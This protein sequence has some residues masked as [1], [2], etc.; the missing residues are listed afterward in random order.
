[1]NIYTQKLIVLSFLLTVFVFHTSKADFVISA[2]GRRH[3]EHSAF[4]ELPFVDGDMS[5]S[6][7]ME[8][9]ESAG[10]WQ[11][12]VGYAP[13][14]GNATNNIDYVLTPQLNVLFRDG[15][16]VGGTGIL[17]SRVSTNNDDDWT[18]LYW[19]LMFGVELTTAYIKL[20]ILAIYPFEGWDTIGD[21]E[22]DDIDYGGA[23]K[24][25]F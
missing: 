16:W 9:H 10:Y 7:G 12:L 15:M 19:Q 8:V 23:L 24:I 4:D 22:F 1:M 14:V 5:Y 17:S 11:L 20:E 21:F 6:I 2:G 13:D 18:D 25:V 3:T